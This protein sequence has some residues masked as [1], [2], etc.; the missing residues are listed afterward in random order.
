MK[1]S[2]FK[3]RLNQLEETHGD[4]EVMI[5]T[6]EITQEWETAEPHYIN[7]LGFVEVY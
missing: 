5:N 6:G 4:V 3:E 1:I 2:D 7:R